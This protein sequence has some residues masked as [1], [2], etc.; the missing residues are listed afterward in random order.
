VGLYG[1][2]KFDK[3][4]LKVRFFQTLKNANHW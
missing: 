4:E 1:V 3:N 2:T